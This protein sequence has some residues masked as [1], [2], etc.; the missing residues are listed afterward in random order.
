ME[1]Y[2]LAVIGIAEHWWL[3]KVEHCRRKYDYVLREG[4]WETGRDINQFEPLAQGA[5][6]FEKLLVQEA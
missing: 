4:E 1:R 5:S 3:G 6:R 2:G